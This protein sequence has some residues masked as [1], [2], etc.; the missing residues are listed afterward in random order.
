MIKQELFENLVQQ[1]HDRYLE[2]IKGKKDIDPKFIELLES[3]DE[4]E[5]KRLWWDEVKDKV[6]PVDVANPC[7]IGTG[8]PDA[9]VLIVGKELGFDPNHVKQQLFIES[10]ENIFQWQKILKGE[11]VEKAHYNNPQIPYGGIQKDFPPRHTWCLYDMFLSNLLHKQYSYGPENSFFQ[12]CFITEFSYLPRNY[13]NGKP[14]FNKAREQIL[15]DPFFKSFDYILLTYR[16]YDPFYQ[17]YTKTLYDVE[18][19]EHDK[20]GKQA[21]VY[22][23]SPDSKRQVVLTNHVSGPRWSNEEVNKLAG[24]FQ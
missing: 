11:K 5:R 20:I 15:S 18:P 19:K 13:S 6:N 16:T 24:L 22:Y 1:A 10:I 4:Q 2:H 8:N 9:N 7:F 23:K 17:G 21:Y 3:D 14:H 12:D